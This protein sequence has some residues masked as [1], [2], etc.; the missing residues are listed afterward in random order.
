[1]KL[2]MGGNHDYTNRT[3]ATPSGW[4]CFKE[5]YLGLELR[6]RESRAVPL[7]T[8]TGSQEYHAQEASDRTMRSLQRASTLTRVMTLKRNAEMG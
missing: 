2:S 4:T 1:M 3:T 8:K 7:S 5:L 6:Y